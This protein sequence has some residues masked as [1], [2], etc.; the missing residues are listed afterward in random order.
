MFSPDGQNRVTIPARLRERV[1]LGRELALIGMG[2]HIAI[3]PRDAWH[4]IE[5]ELAAGGDL[6]D[7]LSDAL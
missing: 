6:D 5:S 3:Y 1:G 7:R 2:H 4:A